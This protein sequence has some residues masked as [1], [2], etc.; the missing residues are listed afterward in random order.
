[1]SNK[2]LFK[3]I[4]FEKINKEENYK[5]ILNNIENNNY[6]KMKWE[7][8]IIP[9]CLILIIGIAL[10]K[11]N[12]IKEN[13]C[14][15]SIIINLLN[16][17]SVQIQDIDAKFEEKNI[18]ELI[19]KFNFITNLNIQFESSSFN[20]MYVRKN[21][22][23]SD[24]SVL[25]GYNLMYVLDDKNT[26]TIDIFFS[27]TKDQRLKCVIYDIDMNKIKN[28]IINNVIIKINKAGNWYMATFKYN[29]LYFDIESHNLTEQEFIGVLKSITA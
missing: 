6:K 2:K 28:S 16:E 1:M 4:Y 20:E 8:A 19:T 5:A 12:N 13:K 17:S 29:N 22:D 21:L 24:Y 3:K 27:E 26:K 9:I 7:L 25:Y 23:D 14:N 15:D 11:N 18:E 10:F